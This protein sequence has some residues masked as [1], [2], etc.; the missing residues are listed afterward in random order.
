MFGRFDGPIPFDTLVQYHPQVALAIRRGAK[1]RP[2]NRIL[3]VKFSNTAAGQ[4]QDASFDEQISVYSIFDGFAHTL[5]PTN[6]F[7]GSTLKY[8]SDT[9]QA[10]TTGITFTLVVRGGGDDYTPIPTPMPLQMVERVLDPSVGTWA[11]WNAANVFARFTILTPPIA[12][13]LTVWAVLGFQQLSSDGARWLCLSADDAYHELTRLGVCCAGP[14]APWAP[15]GA[16]GDP[17]AADAPAGGASRA[18]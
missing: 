16:M 10:Q 5:D 2:N 3:Q 17:A 13:P 4:Y 11:M 15:G 12:S 7:P 14:R 6:A 1:L 9:M 18:P 8:L